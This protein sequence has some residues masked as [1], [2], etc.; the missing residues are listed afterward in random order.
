MDNCAAADGLVKGT[1]QQL[2]G[3]LI[4]GLTFKNHTTGNN[5]IPAIVIHLQGHGD[6]GADL[7]LRTFWDTG[8]DGCVD[9]LEGSSNL[10]ASEFHGILHND[11]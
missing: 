2:S 10:S 1:V 4:N 6:L 3:D 11:I 7:G 5:I 8:I 9:T